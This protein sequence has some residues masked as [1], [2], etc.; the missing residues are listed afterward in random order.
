MD[1]PPL[2][3]DVLAIPHSR[4][5]P[6]R[7]V[8]AAERSRS[9]TRRSPTVGYQSGWQAPKSWQC[10]SSPS[11]S[12]SCD[13]HDGDGPGA[14]GAGG[15]SDA[16]DASPRQKGNPFST[17]RSLFHP[18]SASQPST[19]LNSPP[20]VKTSASDPLPTLN[21]MA[22]SPPRTSRGRSSQDGPNSP[23]S[24]PTTTLRQRTLG[25]LVSLTPK[26]SMRRERE[27]G[28]GL[29][30]GE[31]PPPDFAA[32]ALGEPTTFTEQVSASP[33]TGSSGGTRVKLS[34]TSSRP[35]FKRAMSDSV[36]KLRS[37]AS[38]CAPKSP[39]SRTSLDQAQSPNG[40]A[41]SSSQLPLL[42]S[43][44]SAMHRRFALSELE[45]EPAEFP[46]PLQPVDD[47][48]FLSSSASTASPVPVPF[49]HAPTPGTSPNYSRGPGRLHEPAVTS[50]SS[51]SSNG[52]R[53][54]SRIRHRRS[55]PQLQPRRYYSS[56]TYDEDALHSSSSSRSASRRGFPVPHP[57]LHRAAQPAHSFST[58]STMES[59]ARNRPFSPSESTSSHS[60][61]RQPP[62]LAS[63][64]S[65]W[66]PTPPDSASVS[67]IDSPSW[68]PSNSSSPLPASPS[69]VETRFRPLL[70]R[71]DRREALRKK[72][73]A[74][75]MLDFASLELR[76]PTLSTLLTPVGHP[77]D[78]TRDELQFNWLDE[79][80]L[81]SP[82]SFTGPHS[83]SRP[84]SKKSTTSME[85]VGVQASEMVTTGVQ[86]SLL[87]CG[88]EVATQAGD[89]RLGAHEAG[90]NTESTGEQQKKGTPTSATA[91]A[92][93]ASSPPLALPPPPCP[94]TPFDIEIAVSAPLP[95]PRDGQRVDGVH[96]DPTS[97][98][99]HLVGKVNGV[100][101][102]GLGMDDLSVR[103][104]KASSA[105][106]VAV[107]AAAGGAEEKESGRW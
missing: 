60:Y 61:G 45:R 56:G 48:P 82:T 20:Q 16:A 89:G 33:P 75:G 44:L 67:F 102:E 46:F 54:S 52:T 34:P 96:S 94:S 69:S 80:G 78:G 98:A 28:S 71:N 50:K 3:H 11:S 86:S 90:C 63:H 30:L 24:S 55:R 107:G 88:K 91:G 99:F 101:A 14:S 37:K 15:G 104:F 74:P 92:A 70:S 29:S 62:H 64:F 66:T 97:V 83:R 39:G 40:D 103:S 5:P 43:P 42:Y 100:A 1:S 8:L 22:D 65:D 27:N 58:L 35:G 7:T 72:R 77:G 9:R 85:S 49:V 105:P 106:S 51:S 57:Y 19:P 81:F 26:L 47:S 68:P 41:P 32:T 2:L 6:Q 95:P 21:S 13:P 73:S 23:P 10:D 17:L 93:A 12:S 59:G 53:S 4:P 31:L 36:A 38:Q 25:R 87:L 84:S 76:T 79:D 18:S